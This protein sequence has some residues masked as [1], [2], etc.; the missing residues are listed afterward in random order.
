MLRK[1]FRYKSN[2][3][4]KNIR[5]L[6]FGDGVTSPTIEKFE[7]KNCFLNGFSVANPWSLTC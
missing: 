7:L 6:V 1:N 2:R 4:N 5:N 3:K